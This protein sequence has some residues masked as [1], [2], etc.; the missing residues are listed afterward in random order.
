VTTFTRTTRAQER[1]HGSGNAPLA[2]NH[3]A[4]V[5]GGDVQFKNQGVAVI[6]NLA[7]LHGRWVVN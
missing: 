1:S 4:I 2:A 6:A 5:I 3:F 7:H